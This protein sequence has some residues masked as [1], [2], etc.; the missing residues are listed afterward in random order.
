MRLAKRLSRLGTETAFEVLVKAKALEA[1]GKDIVHLEIGE[2]DF[3]TP[4]GVVA[5]ASQA[6][7][8]GYTHYCA[9]AGLNELRE[10][11]ATEVRLTRGIPV[12]A[13][14]VVVTPGAKPIMFYLILALVE[15]GDEVLYPNPGFP[16]YE[17][18]IHFAGG[19]PVP[20]PLL[21]KYDFRFDLNELKQKVTRQTK[22]IIINSPQNPT[23]GLL[24]E[25]DLKAI[26][27]VAVERD[28]MVL[29]DE[30]YSKIIYEGQHHSISSLPGMLERTVILDG[31]SKTYA[32]TGW[33][34]G[35]GVMAPPLQAHISKLVTN[36]VSCTAPFTQRAGL[37]AL[38]N[39]EKEVYQM[40][41]EFRRRRDFIWK[42]LNE[43][44]GMHSV[45]PAGAF[46]VFPNIQS[47]GMTSS[48]FAD[49]LLNSAGVAVLSGTSFGQY[50]EGYIRISYANSVANLA[51]AADRISESVAK[52]HR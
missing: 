22:L 17:S 14:W 13:D 8:E 32:M 19:K 34:L 20:L 5:A 33:R 40:L 35:Y 42:R 18:M 24:T 51:K 21:E 15:E 23:G 16:I 48:A 10:A 43:I 27:E 50:G 44:P 4:P 7:Q 46:Y 25:G 2:P 49:Y 47:L 39:T 11:I 28:I 26:A 38:A 12:N 30:I 6:L 1:Q 3:P 45:C 52:L 29:S 41:A 37:E 36:S 31:F 9:S